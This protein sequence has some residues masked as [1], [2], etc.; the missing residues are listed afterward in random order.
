MQPHWHRVR[1][2]AAAAASALLLGACAVGPDYVRP[3]VAQPAAFKE[4]N[5]WK[6]AQPNDAALRGNW[7]EFYGDPLLNSLQEQVN[8]SNLSLAQ[9]EAA[10]R[11]ALAL[12]QSARSEY[13]PT[14][15]GEFD[16]TRSSSAT[17]R[18]NQVTSATTSSRGVRTNYGVSL[19]ASWE[20][21]LWGRVRRTVEANA[22]NAQA[23]AADLENTRLS[24]H[25]QLAQNYFQLRALDSQKALLDRTLADYERSLQ[26]TQN[27][28]AA[29][30]AARADVIRA[31]T[32][33]KNTQTQALDIGVQRAQ[34]EHA[35]ALLVGKAPAEFDIAPAPLTAS[36]PDIPLT[37]PS[38]LLE[39]RPDIAA[40]ERRLAAA[41]AEI[42]I[43]KS[44][45]FPSLGLSANV[46]Y[47][48]DSMS[49]LL[50]LPNRFWSIG[51][52]LAQTLL[53]FGAR[54]AQTDQAVAAYDENVALYR[55]TVLTGFQEV[56]DNLAALRI[57]EQ[58]AQTQGEGV[59]LARKSV[60]IATNQYKSGLVSYLDVITAQTTALDSEISA[61]NIL[62]RRLA[63]S[64]LLIKA[65]GGGW[66]ADTPNETNQ[67]VPPTS[68]SAAD[69]T[70]R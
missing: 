10:Y 46:G 13:F 29:G 61:V 58:E 33:L 5:G 19:G 63:A 16:V 47:Q 1:P 6:T 18:N 7:W 41:N 50:T 26:L 59:Q 53:D 64:V 55:Q 60:E 70:S 34:L 22:N 21:D 68:Q 36:V 17:V 4:A 51:P 62:N 42:G 2:L 44:A 37:V 40:A 65:L 48:N 30:I 38:A 35:I 57:L 49:H 45:W 27:Q 67:S 25:A 52:T 54:Q 20:A 24:M 69:T 8:T 11:Q 43:A 56:E 14:V 3:E 32:Q 31:Q 12:V 9:A 66:H 23:S 39:R 28:Y 15:T